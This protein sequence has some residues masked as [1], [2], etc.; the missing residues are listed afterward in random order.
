MLSR[1]DLPEPDGPMTAMSSP[2]ISSIE[3]SRSATTSS[4]PRRKTPRGQLHRLDGFQL[5]GRHG[6]LETRDVVPLGAGQG[7][8]GRAGPTRDDD[9]IQLFREGHGLPGAD[10]SPPLRVREGVVP[11]PADIRHERQIVGNI[12]RRIALHGDRSGVTGR[13][14]RARTR[15][16]GGGRRRGVAART[17]TSGGRQ[18]QRTRQMVAVGAAAVGVLKLVAAISPPARVTGCARPASARPHGE[19]PRCS[20]GA[21]SEPRLKVFFAMLYF[22]VRSAF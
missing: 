16:L 14:V 20:R 13:R 10:A 7:R 6:G 17:P 1:V 11:G 21:Y 8:R 4:C 19:P 12:P 3:T 9:I 22:F 5:E 18:E 15:R 2:A